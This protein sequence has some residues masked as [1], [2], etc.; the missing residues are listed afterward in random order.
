M[1][2]VNITIRSLVVIVGLLVAFGIA[3]FDNAPSP[4][5]EIFGIVVVLFGVYR[6]ITFTMVK[7]RTER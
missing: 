5:H 3:P 7:R 4:F 2:F 1:F 6:L